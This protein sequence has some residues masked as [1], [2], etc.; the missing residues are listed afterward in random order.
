MAYS[1]EDCIE[2][3]K[4]AAKQV[5]GPL[6]RQKYND[7]GMSPSSAT[8]IQRFGWNKTKREAGLGTQE[9]GCPTGHSNVN[10]NVDYF[11]KIDTP[12]KAYWLGMLVGDGYV[13]KRGEKTLS[14]GFGLIDKKH[15]EKFKETISSG[16]SIHE[17]N[18][19]YSIEIGVYEFVKP[20]LDHG[21]TPNKTD[22]NINPDIDPWFEQDFVR[23]YMDA[24][25]HIQNPTNRRNGRVTFVS[26]SKERLEMVGEM[27]PGPTTIGTREEGKYSLR[28]MHS[29]FDRTVEY[30]YPEGKDTQPMLTRK[31]PHGVIDNQ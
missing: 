25:G 9:V 29:T 15:V 8:I 31:Y 17:S 14:L 27:L 11:K 5:D 23:G 16:H 20:L 4:E 30:L 3:I 22:T 24:D 13:R 19:F 7:L 18:G 21:I 26:K 12:E 2:A 10:L 6:S 1:K 28:T